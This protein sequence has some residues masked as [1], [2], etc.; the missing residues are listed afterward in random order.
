MKKL[1]F[2]CGN[3]IKEGWD[4]IDI[5]KGPSISKNFD[6]DKFPYPIKDDIYDY[7]YASCI[8]EHLDDVEKVFSEL[9]RVSKPG[10]IIHIVVPHYTNKGAYSDLQHKHFFNEF[11]FKELEMKKTKIDKKKQFRIV[12]LNLIPTLPGKIFPKN[13]R[14]KLS[15][16]INGLIS[17]IDVKIEVIKN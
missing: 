7:I 5:Q 17:M 2:G 10:G 13:V 12:E 1:N 15:L 16:F 8:M 6:F 14:D 3:D 9:W 4:N 11:C